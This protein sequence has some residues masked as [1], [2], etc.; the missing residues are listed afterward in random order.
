[1]LPERIWLDNEDGR[2]WEEQSRR[3]HD[4]PNQ[5]S[6]GGS[7]EYIRA[8]IVRVV[9]R[10]RAMPVLPTEA[11]IGALAR[12]NDALTTENRKLFKEN[13]DLRQELAQRSQ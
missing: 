1:M 10:L 12:E 2:K 7:T 5:F 9:E 6:A 3:A 13:A 11:Q 4:K 8:D